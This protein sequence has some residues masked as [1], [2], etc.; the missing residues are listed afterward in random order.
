MTIRKDWGKVG[1]YG[2]E[3]QSDNAANDPNKLPLREPDAI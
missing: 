1:K 2:S 3:S